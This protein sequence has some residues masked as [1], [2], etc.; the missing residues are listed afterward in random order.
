MMTTMRR[1][2]LRDL[3]DIT[4]RTTMDSALGTKE[5]TKM[6]RKMRIGLCSKRTTS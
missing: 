5:K 1:G 2:A 3:R 6:R 4:I